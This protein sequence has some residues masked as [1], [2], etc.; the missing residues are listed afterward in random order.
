MSE[1]PIDRTGPEAHKVRTTYYGL[2]A[3][4]VPGRWLDREGHIHR[5]REARRGFVEGAR[6]G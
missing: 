6:I 1:N 3:R 2:R 4:Y 5:Q